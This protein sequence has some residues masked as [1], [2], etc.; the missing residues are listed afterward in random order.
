MLL[1]SFVLFSFPTVSFS[2]LPF[3]FL[4]FFFFLLLYSKLVFT[5]LRIL[6]NWT[7][8]N[9]ILKLHFSVHY[10]KIIVCSMWPGDRV[11]KCV[12]LWEVICNMFTI[13]LPFS[14]FLSNWISQDWWEHLSKIVW[15]CHLVVK[16][17]QVLDV[18]GVQ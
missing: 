12:M 17:Q 14:K 10:L 16:L 4:F 9:H 13:N 5:L 18:W 1:L 3:Y 15:I 7:V 6:N 2:I 11:N 8:D